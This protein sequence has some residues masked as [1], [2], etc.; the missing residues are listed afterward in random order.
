MNKKSVLFLILTVFSIHVFSADADEEIIG[1]LKRNP[2]IY[3]N[4]QD[5]PIFYSGNPLEGLKTFAVIPP[6]SL[7]SPEVNQKIGSIIEKELGSLGTVIKAKD[8]N[9]TGF[10]AGTMLVIQVGNV[11]K[12]DGGQLS[13]SRVSLSIETSVLISKTNIKSFPIVWSINDFVDSPLNLKS[14]SKVEGAVEKMLREFVKNYRFANPKLEEK[15]T[16]YVYL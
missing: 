8:D 12:W 10:G 3:L 6:Y 4:P 14:E 2:G 5:V 16:F 9:V 7:H 1:K 13:L 11:S 15:P